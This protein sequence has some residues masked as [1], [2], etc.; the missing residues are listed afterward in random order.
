MEVVYYHDKTL[1]LCPAKEYLAQYAPNET[2]PDKE[3]KRKDKILV[4]IHAKIQVIKENPNFMA[5]FI[6]S[7]HNHS[8]FEIRTSKN[9]DTVIR[10]LYFRS[11]EKI[12]LLTAFEKPS[13]YDKDRISK[14]VDREYAV[15]DQY[16]KN[17]LKNPTSYEKYE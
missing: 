16:I 4:T 3:R 7:L 13:H 5:R 6:S 14:E 9:K 11:S 1:N 15:A 2:D 10:I 17:F 12:I 8:F